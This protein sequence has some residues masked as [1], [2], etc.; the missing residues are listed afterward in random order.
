MLDTIMQFAQ[1]HPF[2]ALFLTLWASIIAFGLGCDI[3]R[4]FR[5]EH[6]VVSPGGR[7]VWEDDV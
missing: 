5:N 3:A 6:H 4:A 1:A 2:W 7:P